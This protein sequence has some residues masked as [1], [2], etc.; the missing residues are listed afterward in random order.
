METC[1][2][3]LPISLKYVCSFLVKVKNLK[4]NEFMKDPHL[5]ELLIFPHGTSFYNHPLYEKGVLL[6]QDKVNYYLLL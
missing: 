4:E 3:S 2:N 5:P 1:L 6:L